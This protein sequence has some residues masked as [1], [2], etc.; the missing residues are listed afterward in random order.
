MPAIIETTVYQLDELADE[1]KERA[2]SWYRQHGFDHDW[3]DNMFE[4]FG[5]IC[6]L[7]GVDLRTR[8]VRLMSGRARSQPCIFFSGFSSQG[9]GACFEG[10]YRYA[11]GMRRAIRGYAPENIELHRIADALEA[12]QWRNFYQLSATARHRGRYVHEYCMEISV[13]RDSPAYQEP[14]ADAEEEVAGALRNLARWLYRQL[15]REYD[16]QTSDEAVDEAITANEY[17]FT[18]AGRRFG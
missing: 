15:E 14:T 4:D 13:E 3:Y 6:L 8:S 7:L 16:H 5:R 18:K 10:T 17:S 9:D 12:I 1:A 2:R 11:R